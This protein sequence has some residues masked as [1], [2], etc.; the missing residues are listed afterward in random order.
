MN[1][2]N[3]LAL[4]P[5]GALIP[6]KALPAVLPTAMTEE[7]LEESIA[8]I[9]PE[10]ALEFIREI[11]R[12][13]AWWDRVRRECH[14]EGIFDEDEITEAQEAHQNDLD[15]LI[16]MEDNMCHY[17]VEARKLLG[18]DMD[19]NVIDVEATVIR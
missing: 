12:T 15:D 17:I 1:R 6:H 14:E 13:E 8:T 4:I 11:A 19:N 9:D 2:R 18:R 7:Q 5:S 16:W 10:E 3:L